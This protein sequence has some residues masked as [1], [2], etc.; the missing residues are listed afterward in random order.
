MCEIPTDLLAHVLRYSTEPGPFLHALVTTK[1]R[2]AIWSM[3]FPGSFQ[4]AIYYC[5]IHDDVKLLQLLIAHT[6]VWVLKRVNWVRLCTHMPMSLY[7][8]TCAVINSR[9]ITPLIPFEDVKRIA[10]LIGVHIGILRFIDNVKHMRAIKAQRKRRNA[11]M[12]NKRMR[13]CIHRRARKRN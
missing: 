11:I 9:K 6:P 1:Q 13:M 10:N 3:K 5:F 2:R 7:V 8:T 12:C 4:H